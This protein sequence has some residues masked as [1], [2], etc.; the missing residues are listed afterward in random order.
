VAGGFWVA[1]IC[2]VFNRFTFSPL[3]GIPQIRERGYIFQTPVPNIADES[4]ATFFEFEASD[5]AGVEHPS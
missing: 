1:E 2:R 5:A 3:S 4:D